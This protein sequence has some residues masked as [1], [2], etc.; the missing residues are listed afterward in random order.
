[1]QEPQGTRS[2]VIVRKLEDIAMRKT[3]LATALALCLGA[4]GPCLA[5]SVER[6]VQASINADG[7]DCPS[8][9]A[10]KAL[11]KTD[12]GTPIIAA[13]CSNGTRHVLKILP[14]NTLDY[15]STCAVFE[16]MSKVKCF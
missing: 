16:A 5:A 7:K 3:L 15:I 9:T 8:V 10:V 13:A 12:S 2:V 4:P 1:M 14:N 6:M 11:G